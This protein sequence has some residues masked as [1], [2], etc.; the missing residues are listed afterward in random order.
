MR[1]SLLPF[2]FSDILDENDDCKVLNRADSSKVRD[3]ITIKN[4]STV[5]DLSKIICTLRSA[6]GG[7]S[8]TK[9]I[10]IRGRKCS[11][12]VCGT[13]NVNGNAIGQVDHASFVGIVGIVIDDHLLWKDHICHVNN[14]IRR[15]LGALFK[16]RDFVPKQILTLLYKSFIQP[17]ISYG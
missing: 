6:S 9:Y 8:K 7:L 10:L 4:L 15:K 16:L 13:L 14:T 1:L 5:E 12:N 11:L 3:L 2:A 17:H